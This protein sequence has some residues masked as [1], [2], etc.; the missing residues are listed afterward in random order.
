VEE[1]SDETGGL[2][3]RLCVDVEYACMLSS[4]MS[5]QQRA[6]VEDIER[7]HRTSIQLP[8]KTPHSHTIGNNNYTLSV[9]Q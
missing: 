4:S 3:Y 5:R 7:T 2:L 6:A 9:A 1:V 8:N